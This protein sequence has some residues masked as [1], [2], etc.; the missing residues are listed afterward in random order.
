MTAAV[1]PTSQ[2]L[3]GPILVFDSGVGGLSIVEALRERMPDLPLTYACD[4]AAFPYGLK[5]DA[6]LLERVPEVVARLIEQVQPCLLVV[7]C[8]TASTV[9]LP[10]LR[11]R[12]QLPV[13]GVVP[14]IKPAG[15]M[16]RSGHIGLLATQ[17]T[18]QRPYTQRL[19]E[20]FAGDCQVTR[21]GSNRLVELAEE[22]MAG[23]EVPDATLL[24]ILQPFLEEPRLDTMILGC[25]HFPLLQKQLARVAE[26]AGAQHWQWVDSGAAIARR[27]LHLLAEAGYHDPCCSDTFARSCWLTAP[28]EPSSQLPLALRTFGFNQLQQLSLSQARPQTATLDH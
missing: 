9:V 3:P 23:R 22:A 19:I 6:W 24:E 12:F 14:A 16:T 27:V 18:I 13:V 5:S 20:T 25:T 4:N 8:N 26:E 7:A 2:V 21:V 1:C 15:L 10:A 11:E 28:L 17:G